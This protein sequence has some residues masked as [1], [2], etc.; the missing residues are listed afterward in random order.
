VSATLNGREK[1]AA[2]ITEILRTG[3][4]PAT[5]RT[6]IVQSCG[7][8]AED[9]DEL[10]ACALRPAY[11]AHPGDVAAERRAEDARYRREHS[12]PEMPADEER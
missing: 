12:D 3:S 5:Y 7:V 4:D 8:S 11:V 1:A 2:W 10:I 6:S 9:V